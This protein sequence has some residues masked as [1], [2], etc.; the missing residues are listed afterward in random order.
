MGPEADSEVILDALRRLQARP[1][2]VRDLREELALEE[3]RLERVGIFGMLSL[4]FVAGGLLAVANLLVS[5]TM[6]MQRRSIGY[7]VLQALGLQRGKVL[8]TVTLESLVSMAY[9]LAAGVACGVLCARLYVPYFPLSDAAGLP[10]PPFIPLVDWGWT[11]W[12]ASAV[13][14]AMFVAQAVALVRLVRARIF[15]S[16][17]MGVRP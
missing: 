13:T 10:V 14:V 16:L 12:I 2:F 11:V 6:M 3:R 7:A 17:R 15:E 9:G 5:S 1:G 4:C 8:Q